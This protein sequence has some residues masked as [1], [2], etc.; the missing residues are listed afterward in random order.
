MSG[1][2][3]IHVL[4]LN[5]FLFLMFFF[6]YVLIE[7][8]FL[9]KDP[10]FEIILRALWGDLIYLANVRRCMQEKIKKILNGEENK[11]K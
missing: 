10:R 2:K 6:F 5:L 4:C 7:F 11:D 9:R 3:H 8:L 1:E